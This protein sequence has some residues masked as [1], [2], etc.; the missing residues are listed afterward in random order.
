M[1]EVVY[2]NLSFGGQLREYIADSEIDLV[3]IDS[4][5]DAIQEIKKNPNVAEIYTWEGHRVAA[6]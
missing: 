6:F 2:K 5:K 1:F 4:V 3:E